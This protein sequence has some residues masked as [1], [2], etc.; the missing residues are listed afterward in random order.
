MERK[1][2]ETRGCGAAERLPRRL[3][4]GDIAKFCERTPFR[5]ATG[6]GTL[7]KFNEIRFPAARTAGAPSPVGARNVWANE[8]IRQK[9]IGHRMAVGGNGGGGRFRLRVSL[10]FGGRRAYALQALLDQPARNHGVGVL[11]E[12]LVEEGRDLLSEIS[13]MAE[14]GEFVGMQGIAGSGEKEIPRRLSML[15]GHG[16]LQYNTGNVLFKYRSTG[17]SVITS[18]PEVHTLWKSVENEENS[19]RACSGCAGDYE[20]P[21]RSAWEED[22]VQEEPE[23]VGG[24]TGSDA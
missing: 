20:D 14:A 23:E 4:R 9:I 10:G 17:S 19:Q 15:G 12:P 22:F 13:R 2:S 11:V 5:P 24:E 3:F 6:G 18:N 7:G 21:D 1:T 16:R 8:S